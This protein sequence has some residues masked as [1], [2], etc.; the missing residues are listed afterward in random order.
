MVPPPE[1]QI[2]AGNRVSPKGVPGI[3]G[4]KVYDT[5]TRCNTNAG[6]SGSE[7]GVGKVAAGP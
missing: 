5:S 3:R 6:D 4:V 7:A 2:E 1:E